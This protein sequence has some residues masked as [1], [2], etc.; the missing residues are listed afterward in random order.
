MSPVRI[1]EDLSNVRI[2]WSLPSIWGSNVDKYLVKLLKYG[3]TY[4]EYQLLCDG[5]NSTVVAIWECFIPMTAFTSTLNYPL[6]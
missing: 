5:Q 6:G 1:Y 4:S 3:D 2:M